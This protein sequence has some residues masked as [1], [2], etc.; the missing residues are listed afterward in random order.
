MK[1]FTQKKKESSC[2]HAKFPINWVKFHLDTNTTNPS[3]TLPSKLLS[4]S[5]KKE[6]TV[7]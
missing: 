5:N 7:Y 6:K 2:A 1:V 3:N 4:F